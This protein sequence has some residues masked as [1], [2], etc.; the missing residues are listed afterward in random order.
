SLPGCIRSRH[1]SRLLVPR[2]KR[3]KHRIIEARTYD[4]RRPCRLVDGILGSIR[5]ESFR[6]LHYPFGY[7]EVKQR[8]ELPDYRVGRNSS[9]SFQTKDI[10]EQR[11]QPRPNGLLPLPRKLVIS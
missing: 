3:L 11:N 2:T 8:K 9:S 5:E 4:V 1:I 7:E 6:I 10:L